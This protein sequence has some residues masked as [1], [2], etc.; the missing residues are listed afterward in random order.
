MRHLGIVLAAAV[1]VSACAQTQ[2]PGLVTAEAPIFVRAEPSPVARRNA[3]GTVNVIGTPFYALFKAVACV[4]SVVVAAPTAGLV[5]LT[6]RHDRH[7]IQA[8]LH[9]GVGLNCGGSWV[10]PG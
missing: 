5:A 3:A 4:G 2:Q 10:L 9:R 6:D 8:N 7:A 1:V